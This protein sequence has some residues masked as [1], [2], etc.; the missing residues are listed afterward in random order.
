MSV[1]L[2]DEQQR[3]FDKKGCAVNQC[4]QTF[5]QMVAITSK[6]TSVLLTMGSISAPNE[7]AQLP[8]DLTVL[9]LNSGTSMVQFSPERGRKKIKKKDV[10][11]DTNSPT[12]ME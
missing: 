6:P 2:L 1:E 9:G 11:E 8:L 4:W 12:R 5:E 10:V 3:G 7:P